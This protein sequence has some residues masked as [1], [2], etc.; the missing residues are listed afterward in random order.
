MKPQD[1][2]AHALW[3]AER[4]QRTLEGLADVDAGRVVDHSIILDT[5]RAAINEGDASGVAD[6]DVFLRVREKLNL[7]GV[8]L[9][10]VVQ[11]SPYREVEI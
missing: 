8:D 4:H 7:T 6:G 11:A 9:I 10:A 5:L 3:E 2:L 1:R